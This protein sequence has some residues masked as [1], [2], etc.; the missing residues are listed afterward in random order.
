M[1]MLFYPRCV[2]C[3]PLEVWI[4]SGQSQACDL[5]VPGTLSQRSGH[6]EFMGHS[7]RGHLKEA[8]RGSK[9][10]G[11]F[12]YL[13]SDSPPGTAKGMILNSLSP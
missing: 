8:P 11:A 12:W 7:L 1:T 4:T 5:V 3:P 9:G 6:D 10:P 13:L 2:D